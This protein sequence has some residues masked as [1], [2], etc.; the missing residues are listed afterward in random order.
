MSQDNVIKLAQPGEFCST[1]VGGIAFRN[2]ARNCTPCVRSLFHS[3]LAWMNSPAEIVAAWPTTV[4]RSRLPRAFTRR[5]QKP[6]SRFHTASNLS[7]PD[8]AHLLSRS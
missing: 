6:F 8:A 7:R 3:P 2:R 4:M 5:T 1:V